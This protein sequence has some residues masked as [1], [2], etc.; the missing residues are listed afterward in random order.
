MKKGITGKKIT[1]IGILLLGI[2]LLC[3]LGLISL[4]IPVSANAQEVPLS[5]T[6]G[7]GDDLMEL[8]EEQCIKSVDEIQAAVNEYYNRESIYDVPTN[9]ATSDAYTLKDSVVVS[10]ENVENYNCYSYAIGKTEAKHDPG[11]FSGGGF[12]DVSMPVY[13]MA[14]RVKNDLT[15]LGY[16]DVTVFTDKPEV[17][18]KANLI[19]IRTGRN[20]DNTLCDYHVMKYENGAW[21]HKP[22]GTAILKYKYE[23]EKQIWTNESYHNGLYSSPSYTYASDI[24]YIRYYTEKPTYYKY[25]DGGVGSI[26]NPF[27]IS[28]ASQFYNIGIAYQSVYVP[29]EGNVN[30]ITYAFKLTQSITIAGDW[31]PFTYDF[32]GDF[33]G[34][35]HSITYNMSISQTNINANI[36]FGLF[37][38]VSYGGKIH[39][40]EL[41]DCSITSDT[42]T[43]LSRA[44]GNI[45]IGI[46]AGM[47]FEANTLENVN[48]INP[49][50]ECKISNA[51]I[52]AIAGSFYNTFASNCKVVDQSSDPDETPKSS[53]T[54]NTRGHLGGM[55][56]F[57]ETV[58]QFSSCE[59][60]ITLINTV[61]DE[62][63]NDT[64][65]EV[66]S[67]QSVISHDDY[68]NIYHIVV[69]VNMVK[70]EG[71]C[72]SAGSL[73]TL[74]DGTQKP[75]E[76]L[77][78]DEL[79]LVWNMYTGQYDVAPILFVDR[80][81]MQNYTVIN[82][83][84]SNGNTVKVI[85]EHGFWDYDLNRYVY[86]DSNATQYIGHWF[87]SQTTD[88]YGNMVAERVQLV[89]VT[90]QQEMTTAYSP[91]TYGHLCYFVNGML[92]MPGGIEGLF[93]IFE[94]DAE[95]MRYDRDLMQED[96]ERYGLFT[97]EEFAELVPVS[98]EV[99]EA[100]NGQYLKVAIGKGLIDSSTLNDLVNRYASFLACL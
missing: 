58:S 40:L 31:T 80:D 72:L 83:S 77:T 11:D 10:D 36:Y 86:L 75:V 56:G 57:A 84:F 79:L 13:Q 3:S 29:G 4:K 73:I 39:D 16:Y 41:K 9:I 5:D 30:Q 2:C 6:Y 51:A 20:G 12:F 27:L 91:V 98:Q 90:I 64:M 63:K 68:G 37:G 15:A 34:C 47:F 33:D 74:A 28:N 95:T 49:K 81:E 100:F 97:Y 38:T 1:V 21:Y 76:T 78:G 55:A 96:I 25:F 92:S 50:I 18:E 89:D 14:Q 45:N 93:N 53:I 61:Y 99:F 23:P 19:C 7:D 26:E 62:D 44:D 35:G 22:G 87:C 52:G 65:N 85:S 60:T 43:T 88:E 67:N 54:N 17:D 32:T 69:N 24:Y 59:V 71:K 46:V 70:E 82:L 66:I 42:G 48:I 94:V 8:T